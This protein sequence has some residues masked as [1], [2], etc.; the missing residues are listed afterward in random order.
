MADGAIAALLDRVAPFA[1][2]GLIEPRSAYVTHERDG[3]SRIVSGEDFLDAGVMDAGGHGN[4]IMSGFGATCR[5]WGKVRIR[6]SGNTLFQGAHSRVSGLS[7]SIVG[8]NNTVY[9]GSF[10]TAGEVKIRI[11]GSGRTIVVGDRCMLSNLILIGRP[12]PV[13]LFS[14]TSG[15]LFDAP[16]DIRIG[17]Q[18]W[19]GRNV[20]VEPGVTIEAG[21]VVAQCAYVRRG[22]YPGNAVLAGVPAVLKRDGIAWARTNEDNFEDTAGSS[23]HK[24]LYLRPLTALRAR[25]SMLEAE[26]AIASGPV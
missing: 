26:A 25:I 1:A 5:N 11:F 21:S 20:T 19:I 6:G 16:G 2:H 17:A 22:S 18:C 4:V 9:L 8:D 24:Q 13:S 23:H 12:D 3:Y 14:S 15:T 10:A 7:V